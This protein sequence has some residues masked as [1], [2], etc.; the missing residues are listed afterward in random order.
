MGVDFLHTIMIEVEDI[1]EVEIET[2][3]IMDDYIDIISYHKNE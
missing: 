1:V 2:V 3:E